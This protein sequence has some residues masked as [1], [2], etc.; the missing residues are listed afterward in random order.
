M[1]FLADFGATAWRVVRAHWGQ[2][3]AIQLLAGIGQTI[4][5]SQAVERGGSDAIAGLLLTGLG[6]LIAVAGLVATCVVCHDVLA[7]V[8]PLPDDRQGRRREIAETFTVTVLPF[9]L[10]YHS[11]GLYQDDLNR[12]AR[13]AL[14]SLDFSAGEGGAGSI[15]DVQVT[16]AVIIVIAAAFVGRIAIHR[17]LPELAGIKTVVLILLEAVWAFLAAMIIGQWLRDITAYLGNMSV[18][19][20]IRKAL[21]DVVVWGQTLLTSLDFVLAGAYAIFTP[22]LWVTLAGITIVKG[23]QFADTGL[24]R[25]LEKIADRLPPI[26]DDIVAETIIDLRDRWIPVVGAITVLAR[27]G[28]VALATAV[29]IGTLAT[30]AGGWFTAGLAHLPTPAAAPFTGLLGEALIGLGG[31]LTLAATVTV[32]LVSFDVLYRRAHS[33]DLDRQPPE[34]ILADL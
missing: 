4:V 16:A 22:L 12:Y 18:I 9:F 28:A 32:A 3:L 14:N 21:D 17:W 33:S 24:A 1:D 11:W 10:L 2:I 5:H 30:F 26:V 8:R 29:A 13:D 19:V 7:S 23:N 34:R 31:Q 6:T 20:G 25:R 27:A 15:I